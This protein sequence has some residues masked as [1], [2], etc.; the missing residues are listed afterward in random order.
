MKILIP[1]YL[2]KSVLR[3]YA[4]L[5]SCNVDRSNIRAVN[6]KRVAKKEIERVRKL[7]EIQSTNDKPI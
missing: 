5:A 3:H 4:A 6:A 2:L 1:D 7:I